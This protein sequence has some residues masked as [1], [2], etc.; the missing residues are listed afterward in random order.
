MQYAGLQRA[1]T[2]GQHIFELLDIRPEITDRAGALELPNIRGE[3]RFEH[4]Y[5]HY[6]EGIPILK[7]IDV[8]INSGEKIALVGPTGAGKTTFVSLVSRFYDPTEGRITID[9]I[10][11]RDIQRNSFAK[12]TGTVTQDPFLFSGT[13]K[14][15]IIFSHPNITDEQ[16]IQAA[17]TIG[18]HNFI[19][20]LEFG[21]NTTIEERGENLSPGERQLISLTRAV[22]GNPSIVIL[23]EATATV[24]SYTEKII[25]DGLDNLLKERTALI[26]AHRLSTVRNADRIFVI[27]HGR[28]IEQG[29][30]HELLSLGGTYAQLHSLNYASDLLSDS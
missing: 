10:D 17:T 30:H 7:D 22:I 4:V 27:D 8:T 20:R 12:Q 23:D 16:V 9:K 13:I 15:N 6:E 28:I 29:N 26:V 19:S 11:I 3:I 2:S 1:M 24:D 21:Y 14:D 18:A 25:Q 5:F